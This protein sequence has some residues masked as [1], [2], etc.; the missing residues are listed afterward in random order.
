MTPRSPGVPT[1]S[2]AQPEYHHF[3]GYSDEPLPE[4]LLDAGFVAA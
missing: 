1:K 2:A 3:F 4:L